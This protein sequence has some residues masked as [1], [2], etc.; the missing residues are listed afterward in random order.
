MIP[1]SNPQMTT[2]LDS[3]ASTP[4]QEK[5]TNALSLKR[6]T[7]LNLITCSLYQLYWL[8][9]SAKALYERKDL[10]I[11]PEVCLIGLLIP[12]LNPFVVFALFRNIA[13]T[14]QSKQVECDF[15]PLIATT[16]LTISN[17]MLALNV[18]QGVTHNEPTHHV[19]L[20]FASIIFF[21]FLSTG[22]LWIEQKVLNKF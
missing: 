17:C 6:L 12:A 7:V 5:T 21:L 18:W 3:L 4:L 14:A 2:Q 11:L 15:S 19:A 13:K 10:K 1:H 22:V 9:V 16:I 8:Y 20:L